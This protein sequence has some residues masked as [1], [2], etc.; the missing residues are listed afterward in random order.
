MAVPNVTA[1]GLKPHLEGQAKKRN[2]RCHWCAFAQD[3]R[4]V[5]QTMTSDSAQCCRMSCS[6][7]SPTTQWPAQTCAAVL[8]V[9]RC[10][11]NQYA[12]NRRSKTNASPQR[13]ACVD[14][15]IAAVHVTTSASTPPPSATLP[16]ANEACCQRLPRESALIAMLQAMTSSSKRPRRAS[17][18]IR[19]SRD[20]GWSTPL[21]LWPA[22]HGLLRNAPTTMPAIEG[23]PHGC[24]PSQMCGG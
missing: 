4:I 12:R 1:S 5:L 20:H 22:E 8:Y 9:A 21:A 19:I 14:A 18:N 17:W 24:Q 10:G 3:P 23:C 15:P 7:Q 13:R 16:N 11:F 2:A 6:M